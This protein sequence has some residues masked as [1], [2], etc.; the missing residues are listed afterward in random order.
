[1]FGVTKMSESQPVVLR[2]VGGW[3]CGGPERWNRDMRKVRSKG[4]WEVQ[5]PG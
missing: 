2:P 1:V 5:S 3:K 4:V